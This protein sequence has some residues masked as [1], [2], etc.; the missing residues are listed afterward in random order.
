MIRFD[1]YYIFEPT[2]FQERKEMKP[3][4]LIEAYLFLKNGKLIITNKF[5]EN[6]D[7][8]TFD[9]EDFTNKN[10][11]CYYINKNELYYVNRCQKGGYKFYHD[12]ISPQKIVYRDSG[13]ILKFVPWKESE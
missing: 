13:K 6:K 12:I 10:E 5:E 4:Y 7:C 11:H 2:L 8:S 9:I 1:G 3:W